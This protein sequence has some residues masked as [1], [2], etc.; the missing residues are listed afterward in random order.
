MTPQLSKAGPYDLVEVLHR[1]PRATTY[2]AVR[3]GTEVEVVLKMGADPSLE[4][5]GSNAPPPLVHRHIVQVLE[6]GFDKGFP[7][8]VM[9]RLRG[10]TLADLIADANFVADL[11]TRVD[12]VAQVCLGLHHA[13]EQHLVH[14]NVRPDNVFVTD[15]GTA[16][17][18]NFMTFSA[19]GT[20]DRTMVSDHPLTGSFEYM[21]P[22][23]IIGRDVLD[24]RS[25]VFSAAVVLY[26]LIAGRRPFHG[27]STT[28]TLARILR[29][30][31][32]ALDV[33]PRLNAILKRALDKEAEKRFASAQEFAY[34]LWTM[35]MPEAMHEPDAE[36]DD[37]ASATM[38][39]GA[40]HEE[41]E[42]PAVAPEE[43][44]KKEGILTRGA[45]W[46]RRALGRE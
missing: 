42:A 34:A 30:D 9:E 2:V 26:E 11:P 6:Q 43:E 35:A 17:I 1:G 7:Y 18:L 5:G 27:A 10:R 36:P 29:D 33:P 16:K 15:D 13:H 37:G 40:A 41:D 21:S 20:G 45:R 25:D 39:A 8:I 4:E 14:G 19:A 12:M 32:P 22:E 23:Q 28:A 46:F 44:E 3:D 24:G 31:P 38:I